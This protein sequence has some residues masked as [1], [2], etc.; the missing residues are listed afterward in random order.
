M[1]RIDEVASTPVVHDQLVSVCNEEKIYDWLFRRLFDGEPYKEKN[2]VGFF[3]SGAEGW[4]NNHSF[5]F[6]LVT[7]LG[8][9]AAAIDIKAP[10]IEKSEIGYWASERHRGCMTNTVIALLSIA[11]DAG[12]RSLFARVRK[13]NLNS[14]GVLARSGFTLS[15]T[16]EDETYDF[17]RIEL[18]KK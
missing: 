16:D 14:V 11:K 7:E 6:L 13:A 9:V 17:Y 15:P 5:V 18:N 3:R 12:Y 1:T 10:D 8:E 2:S 4:K